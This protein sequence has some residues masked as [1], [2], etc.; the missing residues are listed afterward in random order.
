MTPPP[1]I[2]TPP[3]DEALVRSLTVG[4][5]VHITGC[6]YAARDAAHKRMIAALDRN[7]PLPFDVAG[8]IIYYVGPTP[9]GP[10][11]VI[12]SAGPTSSYRMDAYTPRLLAMGLRATMGKGGRSREVIEAQ[13]MHGAVYLAATGGAGALLSKCITQ[14]NILAYEDLGPEAVRR[15]EVVDFPAVVAIDAACNSMYERRT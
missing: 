8:A 6:V 7:E 4:T 15:L 5:E 9:G 10:G 2:L 11:R 13:K 14:A 12:G 3:L 1:T